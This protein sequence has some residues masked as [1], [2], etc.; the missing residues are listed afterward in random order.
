M[1]RVEFRNTH[2]EGLKHA[3]HKIF[4]HFGWSNYQKKSLPEISIFELPRRE[5]YIGRLAL[6]PLGAPP[7]PPPKHQYRVKN[8]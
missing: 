2:K 4:D 8:T 5:N 6:D 3:L 1:G 7:P